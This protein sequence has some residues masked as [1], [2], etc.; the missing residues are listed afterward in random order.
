MILPAELRQQLEYTLP[1]DARSRVMVKV[2]PR[3]HAELK[4][5][6]YEAD[7]YEIQAYYHRMGHELLGPLQRA[8]QEVPGVYLTT[9]IWGNFPQRGT[10]VSNPDWPERL[11]SKRR[12]GHL[13]RPQVMGLIRAV[14]P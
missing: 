12:E 10:T 11:G 8:L 4:C 5:A 13:L 2:T 3:D 1:G 9:Q 6:A 14:R 7:H